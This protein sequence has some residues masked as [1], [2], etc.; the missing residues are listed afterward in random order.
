MSR[1]PDKL[2]E[3]IRVALADLR[4]VE[5]DPRYIVNMANWHVAREGRCE[6]CL[7]GAVMAGTLG[8]DPQRT[9]SPFEFCDDELENKLD[10]LDWVRMGNVG[11]ANWAVTEQAVD[12]EFIPN[13]NVPAYHD[14]PEAFHAALSDLANRLEEKGL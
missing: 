1:L 4:K 9:A 6:V 3:L 10:A 14:G 7:A 2:S 11:N 13:E 8:V 12:P 5:A